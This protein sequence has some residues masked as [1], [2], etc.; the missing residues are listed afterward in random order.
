[1]KIREIRRLNLIALIKERGLQRSDWEKMGID[2]SYISRMKRPD[3]QPLTDKMASKIT[4]NLDLPTNYFDIDRTM[5][6]SP[7]KTDIFVSVPLLILHED[8]VKYM[9]GRLKQGEFKTVAIQPED[10]SSTTFAFEQDSDAMAAGKRPIHRGDICVIDT[11]LT[12]GLGDIV[13]A[14]I[15][16]DDK[17]VVR[18]YAV[19]SGK[20]EL[21]PTNTSFS[22]IHMASD[23]KIIGVIKRVSWCPLS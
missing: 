23:D 2:H 4:G 14:Y 19:E 18:K 8:Y 20:A 9:D 15:L 10:Y 6:T 3:E 5:P 22:V 7:I 1:M 11:A 12:P 21:T 13:A 16:S 17:Y